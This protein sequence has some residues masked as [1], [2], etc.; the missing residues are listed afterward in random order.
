MSQ[1]IYNFFTIF[2]AIIIFAAAYLFG[3]FVLNKTKLIKKINPN[4]VSPLSVLLGYGLVSLSTLI[5]SFF[6]PINKIIAYALLLLIFVFR[7]SDFL[8]LIRGLRISWN[9]IKSYDLWE[10]ILLTGIFF[11]FIFYLTS[12]LVPPYRTDALAYHLPEAIG[13]SNNGIGFLIKGTMGNFF[14]NLPANVEV[15][16]ATL[17]S[18]GGF[19]PI[20]LVHYSILLAALFFIFKFTKECFDRPKALLAILLTFSLYDLFVNGTN[21]YVDAVMISWEI[22]GLL[23]LLLWCKSK[24]WAYLIIS[25]F[26]YGMALGTKYNALYGILLAGLILLFFS[27]KSRSKIGIFI[28]NILYF[29][30][31]ILVVAGFWYFKNLILYG[32]PVYPF[33]FGHPGFQDD[34][35]Q[36]MNA[37]VK[38]FI[39]DRNLINFI[40]LPFIFFLKSYYLVMFLAF[41]S[42]PFIFISNK[43]SSYQKQILLV[44]SFYIGSYSLLWFFA[45][46]HQLKFFYGP[47]IFLLLIFAIQLDLIR[48]FVFKNFNRKIIFLLLVIF[49][50]G[51]LY[52]VVTAKN[53]YFIN[54]KKAELAY[55]LGFDDKFEFYQ[56]KDMGD[57]YQVSKFINNNFKDVAWLNIW[58]TANFFLDNENKFIYPSAFIYSDS[59]I[60]TSTLINYMRENGMDRVII[61]ENGRKRIRDDE[62]LSKVCQ[63][64]PQC[65]YYRQREEAIE[66]IV[67]DSAI[68]FYD[69]YGIKLYNLEINNKN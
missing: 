47:M 11:C 38:S 24:E 1:I 44:L 55:S 56:K 68:P 21:A 19:T 30:L 34:I 7:Y 29:S 13:V 51:L 48:K 39:V 33:Y 27:I 46:T 15:M 9:N 67:I 5:L 57:V 2:L 42:W 10:K 8:N 20:H 26:F 60:S 49:L 35:Y 52:K 23:L 66:K 53:N 50:S 41:I 36:Q 58:N 37:G 16:D 22:S 28:K 12:A 62:F 17:Y 45:I 59:E 69:Q 3:L 61:D 63:K 65:L 25:G 6:G 18:L 32:N 31:P 14:K 43:F 40:L 4:F 54:V 64:D